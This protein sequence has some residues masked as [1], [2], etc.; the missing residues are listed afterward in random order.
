MAL[1]ASA[2]FKDLD[3]LKHNF[4]ERMLIES[5]NDIIYEYIQACQVA[6]P[7]NAYTIDLLF[8]QHDFRRAPEP[9][10]DKVT[11]KEGINYY[12][13]KLAHTQNPG[14]FHRVIRKIEQY[15]VLEAVVE[16]IKSIYDQTVEI[17]IGRLLLSSYYRHHYDYESGFGGLL[18]NLIIQT[19]PNFV[20]EIIDEKDSEKKPNFKRV[21]AKF[22]NN[23]NAENILQKLLKLPN[24]KV[25]AFHTFQHFNQ[26]E[27]EDQKAAYEMSKKYLQEEY[28]NHQ[29]LISDYQEKN[30]K[31]RDK[32]LNRLYEKFKFKLTPEEG[33]YI[34]D[35]FEFYQTHRETLKDKI[36]RK[37]VERLKYLVECVLK[38]YDFESSK[39]T[40]KEEGYGKRTITFS[41]EIVCFG[42]VLSL[43]KE[44]GIDIS[45]Y[46]K[47]IIRYI[48]F[49]Y[50]GQNSLSP[51]FDLIPT[52]TEEDVSYL[53]SF[54][55]S[56][57]SD[58]L[59]TANIS[60]LLGTIKKYE[61]IGLLPLVKNILRNQ[62]FTDS[63]YEFLAFINEQEPDYE[64]NYHIL[65]SSFYTES[66]RE[67]AC[68]FLITQYNPYRFSAIRYRLDQISTK[69][70][71]YDPSQ[72]G[73]GN[74]YHDIS[75]FYS[76][77]SGLANVN[78][79]ELLKDFLNLFKAS[80][81]VLAKGK[82]YS[83][84]AYYAWDII[85]KYLENVK[86]HLSLEPLHK[87]KKLMNGST[88][89]TNNEWLMR[90]YEGLRTSYNEVCKPT[91]FKDCV[92]ST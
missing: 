90:R 63:H 88:Y 64:L 83:V 54:Y 46:R 73:T 26:S 36:S 29:S 57:R 13:N 45:T 40:R 11:S 18:L 92:H 59:H 5:D 84:S 25:V 80:L 16:N 66:V 70:N 53:T 19:N 14:E 12:L 50:N 71:G 10:F 9:N 4:H 85:F 23:A 69:I 22:I 49:A 82:N 15:R 74:D 33:K 38:N 76:S 24:G 3:L 43:I 81:D 68:D 8:S 27:S 87:V 17:A 7:N 79:I 89:A 52:I 28:E 47:K 6:A 65:T 30:L 2:Q 21:V 55:Q 34:T 32:R 51:I 91:S 39:V 72:H 41:G 62:K 31:E 58:D 67:L 42:Q 44:L 37:D 78:N 1:D 86:V 60:N 48:P 77:S 75:Y 61:V 35:V 56:E 20:Y